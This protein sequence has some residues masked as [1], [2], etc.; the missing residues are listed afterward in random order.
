M[1]KIEEWVN[2]TPQNKKEYLQEGLIL[3]VTEQI[4]ER[5]QE[6]G[7]K[8]QDLAERLDCGKSHVTQLLNGG[9]NMT[10]RTLSDIAEAINCEVKISVCE[11]TAAVNP[12][13]WFKKY[14]SIGAANQS[15]HGVI[16]SMDSNI[17]PLIFNHQK[18]NPESAA[19]YG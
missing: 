16:A 1:N 2:A 7:L 19:T 12:L 4:W 8:K 17:I 5:M 6:L 18:Y 3:D 15:T 14:K 11:N 10:L 13:H 9:R